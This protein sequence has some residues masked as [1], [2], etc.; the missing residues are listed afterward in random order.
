MKA[1][2]VSVD[3]LKA[4][5]KNPRR[6][7]IKLIAESLTEYGQYKPIVV[8]SVNNEILVGNHTFEAAKTLGW[9]EIDVTYIEADAETAA[10]IVLIDNRASDLSG[11][12]NNALLELLE[13][14]DSLEHTGYGDD[15]FDDVL[16]KIE[17]EK[18][19]SVKEAITKNSLDEIA[20]QIE[21]LAERYKSVDTKVFMVEL[22]NHVYIWTIEQ[23]GK[24][25]LKSGAQSNSDALVKLLEE[26]YGEKAPE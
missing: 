15:E 18:T 24:Q 16:A 13:R 6:G 10:K 26:N 23:L 4:Y 17:E 14:L 7:N 19:P 12:D 20:G 22:E 2:K 9:K 8:N 21:G 5:P 3:E 11:Y 25:R 1:V